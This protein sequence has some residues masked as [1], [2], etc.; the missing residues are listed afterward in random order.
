MTQKPEDDGHNRADV[1]VPRWAYA[2]RVRQ[3][4]HPAQEYAR[5]QRFADPAQRQRAERHAQLYGGQKIVQIPLQP[6][7]GARARRTGGQHLLDARL[8]DRN[9][10]ELRCHEEPVG[11]DQHGHGDAFDRQKTVHLACEHSIARRKVF[12][13]ASP[14]NRAAPDCVFSIDSRRPPTSAPAVTHLLTAAWLRRHT[15]GLLK[16]FG[17]LSKTA[18]P[19]SSRGRCSVAAK[20]SRRLWIW[21]T[22]AILIVVVGAGVA[23]ARMVSGSSIDPNRIAKAARGDVARSVVATGK[24]Q[25]I[26]KVE[27]KSKASG[28]V[29]KLFVD[30]N[31][32]VSKGQPL[33]QLDQQ[34]I[35]A[36]VEAQKAQLAAAEANVGT[37]DANI[38]QDQVNATPRA[39]TCPCTRPL[40]I[41]TCRCRKKAWSRSRPST[42]PIAITLPN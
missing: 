35:L 28:I 37:Y 31:N 18:A 38:E 41:A 36:Q 24:I 21:V 26:T 12:S 20:K 33:A 13:I 9:Q 23:L 1:G 6:A 14:W 30:I 34:E 16:F 27:V 17:S 25:P 29:E 19:L 11:Q 40:S 15:V 2:R 3:H 4:L 42:T 10:R 32:K 8:A 7:N 5:R 39:P 22:L